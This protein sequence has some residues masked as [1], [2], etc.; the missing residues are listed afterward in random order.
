MG[1]TIAILS[2]SGN[3]PETID[4]LIINVIIGCM[5]GA[6]CLSCLGDRL[7]IPLL[8]F[9]AMVPIRLRTYSFDTVWNWN[10]FSVVDY[11]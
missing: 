8:F 5:V 10:L 7:S 2:W 3:I 4:W 1:V 6:T 9:G 11:K